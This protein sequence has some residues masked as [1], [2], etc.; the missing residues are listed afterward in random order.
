MVTQLLDLGFG[1]FS[2][3]NKET[4]PNPAQSSQL[5]VDG[6]LSNSC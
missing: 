2:A 5:V 3:K 6:F 4:P 1:T